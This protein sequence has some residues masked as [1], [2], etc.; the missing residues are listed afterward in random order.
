MKKVKIILPTGKFMEETKDF[1]DRL[2]RL[3]V[4]VE[5]EPGT[6]RLRKLKK[7]LETTP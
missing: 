3:G 5:V 7:I 6:I 1:G 4:A 2:I